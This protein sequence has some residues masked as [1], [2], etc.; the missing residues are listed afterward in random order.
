[1]STHTTDQPVSAV[2][3]QGRDTV[4]VVLIASTVATG[5]IA[6]TYYIFSIAVMPGLGKTDD[7]VFVDSMQQINKVIENPLFFAT[8]FG[9]FALPAVAVWQLRKN[10]GGAAM[11]WTAAALALYTVTLLTTMGINVPLN[12]ELKDAGDPHTIAN[13]AQ[14]R[15]DFEDKWNLWNGVRA[16][17]STA[18][19]VC[20]G[21]ALTLHRRG[22]A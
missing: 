12:N 16:V 17:L 21:R 9:A 13:I 14:V 7:A 6:G 15:S 22:R 19:V 11:K 2:T 4:G 10:G 18:A 1:M 20:L 3:G 5:L 8:F